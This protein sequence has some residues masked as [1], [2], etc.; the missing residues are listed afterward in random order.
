MASTANSQDTANDEKKKKNMTNIIYVVGAL[1]G[2]GALY[3]IVVD[4]LKTVSVIFSFSFLRFE[5]ERTLKR[6]KRLCRSTTAKWKRQ[7]KP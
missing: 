1:T 3:S 6:N 7:I 2:L 5:I 4:L